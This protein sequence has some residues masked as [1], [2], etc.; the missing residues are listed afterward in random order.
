[1]TAALDYIRATTSNILS[2]EATFAKK[3]SKGKSSN[4]DP[5]KPKK[6]TIYV[7]KKFPAW[8]DKYIDLVRENFDA[9]NLSVNDKSLNGQVGKLG[10]MKKAMPFVQGLKRRLIQAREKPEIVFNRE[11][12]FDEVQVLN[13]MLGSLRKFTG[14]KEVVVL[15]VEEGCEFGTTPSGEKVEGLSPSSNSAVPGQPSFH[16]ENVAEA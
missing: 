13:E 15:S 1:M 5:R 11:L 14:S 4:F 8:Q 10:E 6:L 12:G 3:L 7:A 16:F 9:I 2:S